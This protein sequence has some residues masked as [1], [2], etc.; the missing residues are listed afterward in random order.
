MRLPGVFVAPPADAL[1]DAGFSGL[2]L[3]DSGNHW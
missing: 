1:A 3:K 2:S